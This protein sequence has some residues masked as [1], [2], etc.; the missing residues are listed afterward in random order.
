M[1]G[2]LFLVGNLLR[3]IHVMRRLKWRV[4]HSTF[5]F[6]IP[7]G[8]QIFLRFQKVDVRP[9]KVDTVV[10]EPPLV[11]SLVPPILDAFAHGEINQAQVP[12]RSDEIFHCLQSFFPRRDHRQ[13]IR[14]RHQINF[15]RKFLLCLGGIDVSLDENNLFRQ[16]E[17]LYSSFCHG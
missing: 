11:Q 1:I 3:A 7:H 5:V 14:A 16:T 10:S 15:S 17:R 13:A 2:F 12:A 6:G 4:W 9:I 8:F